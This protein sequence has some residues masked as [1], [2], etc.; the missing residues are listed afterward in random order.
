M[1]NPQ[2]ENGHTKIANELV[3]ALAMVNLSAYESRLLW[4]IFRKTYGWNKK[5]DRISYSQFANF[6]GIDRRHIGRALTEPKRRQIIVCSGEGYNLEY[7]IQKD[8]DLW[9]DTNSGAKIDTN[10]GN[11]LTPKEATITNKIDTNLGND[12]TPKEATLTDMID[13]NLGNDLTPNLTP[14]WGGL[15]PK[16]ATN[17]TPKEVYTKERKHITKEIC[18][19]TYTY[20]EFKNIKLSEN[21]YQKLMAKF[22]E[23]TAKQWIETLSEGIASKGYKYKSHYA[24]ILAWHRKDEK[25]K[26]LGGNNGK[27]KGNP[28]QK[29]AGAFADLEES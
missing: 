27:Y 25:E 28:S 19:Y 2:I 11:D 18:T 15:T 29:P 20:G 21:E 26:Q 22:G 13:T 10:L 4:V 14:I 7:G 1:A 24:T 8:F 23:I 17:L 5:T 9:I 12:L 6:T 3:E 16:E